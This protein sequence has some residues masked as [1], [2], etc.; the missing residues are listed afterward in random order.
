[1]PPHGGVE[2][3]EFVEGRQKK[4]F[5]RAGTEIRMVTGVQG[6]HL[7][8]HGKH[9]TVQ[10][11]TGASRGSQ[12]IKLPTRILSVGVR[13]PFGPRPAGRP[14]RREG[15]VWRRRRPCLAPAPCEN[16]TTASRPDSR[17]AQSARETL[18]SISRFFGDPRPRPSDRRGRAG[19]AHRRMGTM[20][21]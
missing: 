5:F 19:G 7:N 13:Q 8:T 1:M 18:R 16:A 17:G 9:A 6:L 11:P 2:Q 14:L 15:G 21:L 10:S 4:I 3:V 20:K 12:H